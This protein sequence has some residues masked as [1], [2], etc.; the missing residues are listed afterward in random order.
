M[1]LPAQTSR[2]VDTIVPNISS[3]RLTSTPGS[4]S[5]YQL[6]ETIQVQMTFNEVV[7]VTGIPQLTL[8]IGWAYKNAPYTGGTGTQ[9]LFFTYTVVPGDMD[10]DGIAIE[11]NALAGHGHRC[12]GQ[13]CISDKYL[14]WHANRT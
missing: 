6:R 3:I 10:A 13:R 2:K 7:N 5:T 12:C 4:D 1:P 14:P 9:N 11:A 8:K